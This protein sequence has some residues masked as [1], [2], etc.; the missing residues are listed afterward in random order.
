[1]KWGM[2]AFVHADSKKGYTYNQWI[3]GSKN[4][5]IESHDLAN[6]SGYTLHVVIQVEEIK[7]KKVLLV[8]SVIFV[9]SSMQVGEKWGGGSS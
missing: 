2:K 1:M 5:L 7:E 8:Y 3:N 9:V 4:G 6:L